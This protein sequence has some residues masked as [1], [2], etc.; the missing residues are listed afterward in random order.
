MTR[1]SGRQGGARPPRRYPPQPWN[2]V[3]CGHHYARTMSSWLVLLA[4]TGTQV[5]ADGELSFSPRL[6]ASTQSNEF[7]TFWSAGTAWGTFRQYRDGAAG[8][9]HYEVEVLGGS[10]DGLKVSVG[11]RTWSLVG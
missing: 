6:E 7:R 11:D 8:E 1:A 2:E 4:L 9:W 3:E 10:A 5:N